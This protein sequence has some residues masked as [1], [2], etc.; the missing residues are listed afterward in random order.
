[1][2]IL[3]ALFLVKNVYSDQSLNNHHTIMIFI[4]EKRPNTS[5]T[6]RKYHH[7]SKTKVIAIFWILY[8]FFPTWLRQSLKKLVRAIGNMVVVFLTASA[9]FRPRFSNNNVHVASTLLQPI[10]L[11]YNVERSNKEVDNITP[12]NKVQGERGPNSISAIESSQH[13]FNDCSFS[14][15]QK[16]ISFFWSNL[17]KIIKVRRLP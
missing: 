11:P 2:Q 12:I 15:T 9:N 5:I 6:W 13:F 3:C 14:C 4:C 8:D 16:N 10:F 1:M 17:L 7:D